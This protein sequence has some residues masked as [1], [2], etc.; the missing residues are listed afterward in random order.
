MK[1]EAAA[2]ASTDRDSPKLL[3][4]RHA[5]LDVLVLFIAGLVAAFFGTA[6]TQKPLDEALQDWKTH[7]GA[8]PLALAKTLGQSGRFADP[9]GVPT[10]P[11]AHMGPLFPAY[12]AG[13]LL[14]AKGAATRAV[15]LRLGAALFHAFELALLPL[16][17][18]AAFGELEIGFIAGLLAIVI[19]CYNILP[20]WD[21]S[22]SGLATIGFCF[23][24]TRIDARSGL[25]MAGLG[26]LWGLVLL[27]NPS[28]A[29]PTAIWAFFAARKHHWPWRWIV[30]AVLMTAIICAPW[31][32]RN[33]RVLGGFAPIRDNLGL[34][35]Q[36]SNNDYATPGISR[37]DVSLARFHPSINP[38]QVAE[39]RERGELLYNRDKMH[40][41]AR[42]ILTNP[43]RFAVLTLHRFLAFWFPTTDQGLFP[44]G[45]C[46]VTLLSVPG[47]ILAVV[48]HVRGAYPL[49]WMLALAPLP[50]YVIQSDA[51]YRTPLLWMSLLFAGYAL[52]AVIR[53]EAR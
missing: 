40:E 8:E 6:K 14:V 1:S 17:S 51:R 13:V 48:R 32:V 47:I 16:L 29:I 19:P 37:N 21:S 38:Q 10:G 11:S 53:S 9:F 15:L 52:H 20:V 35:L 46:I 43:R 44:T 3:M 34:E 23:A 4:Q 30:L 49:L 28:L 27:L 41:A 18:A 36:V 39:I 26:G 7:A 2:V 50:F 22:L 31:T 42:W 33:Y 12:L 24:A 25:K 45:I 5:R